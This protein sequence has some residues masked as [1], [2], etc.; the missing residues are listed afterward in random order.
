MSPSLF[1]PRLEYTT[2]AETRL[3]DLDGESGDLLVG[4]YS[5]EE[6][7][8]NA[9]YE[10]CVF[11]LFEGRLPTADELAAFRA[12][13][14]DRR[15]I[16]DEVRAVLRRAA[17]ADEPAMSALR[18]GLA[19][20]T[21][22]SDA[23]ESRVRAE[24]V[25]AVLPT[26]AATYRRYR[27][28]DDPVAPRD[29]LGHAAN[30]LYLLTGTEPTEAEV[31][32]LEAFLT[33]IVEH[34]LTASTFTAR[35]VISTESDLVSATTAALGALKGPRHAGDLGSIFDLLEGAHRADDVEAYARER[36]AA[37]ERPKGFGHPVY[38][39]RD[40]RAAVLSAAAERFYEEAGEPA[41]LE[42]VREFEATV[43]EVL[44]ERG[45][46]GDVRATVEF[47]AAALLHGIGIP[48]ALFPATFAVSR[49]GGWAAHCLEQRD[50][51]ALVRPTA[52]YVGPTE[53]TWTPVE[54]R[55]VAGDALVRGPVQSASLE[56]VS[57]TL[58]VLSEPDRLEILLLLYDADEPLAYSTLRASSSIEDKG[59]FNYHLRQLREFF[60]VKRGD[61]YELTE[62]GETVVR[63]I[64]TDDRLLDE[65]L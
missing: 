36:V 47:Y 26:I 58:A 16:G 4:G 12:D 9:G 39:V 50:E 52:R 56:P 22:D 60:A 43:A 42:S 61:G 27:R 40:P 57:E 15:E 24:R 45:A 31:R 34:G 10:E 54:D 53:K 51:D 44:S 8:V 38:R 1:D 63:S 65:L 48:R 35:T 21:L 41:L 59:R 30:Y 17:A 55:H 18:M 64:L 25:V 32:G 19:A 5:I 29:D 6:L 28:G 20:A 33:T 23:A 2:V 13:L 11:L 7:A 3:S 46:D 49:I 37:G 62:A 14:A